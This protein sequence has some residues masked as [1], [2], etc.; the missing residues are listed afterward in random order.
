MYRRQRR[1]PQGRKAEMADMEEKRTVRKKNS[2]LLSGTVTA[3]PRYSHISHGKIFFLF[4]MAVVRRS[5]AVDEV[6]VIISGKLLSAA[7]TE[8]RRGVRVRV[9]GQIR[10]Y[11]EKIEPAEMCRNESGRT[12]GGNGEKNIRIRGETHLRVFLFC[13]QIG[14]DSGVSDENSIFLDG[15]ICRPPVRRTA[16]L[17]R[18]ICDLLLAVN[19]LY[20]K[21][22]YIPCIAWGDSARSA[23]FFSVG[24][25]VWLRGRFQSREYRKCNL[26]GEYGIYV[27]YEV[28]AAVIE[29]NTFR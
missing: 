5:G 8:V 17:G 10:T 15:F 9:K 2:A 23:S 3:D 11:N 21:S 20:G 16:P 29:K 6:N 22:D 18:E 14:P 12:V 26:R 28:S 19:R 1:S 27:S 13:L 7:E 24:D 25:R 4:R